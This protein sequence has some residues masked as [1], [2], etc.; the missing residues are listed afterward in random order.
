MNRATRISS[1]AVCASLGCATLTC[2]TPR[3]AAAQAPSATSGWGFAVTPYAW[4][5]G[6]SGTVGVGPLATNVSLDFSQLLRRLRFAA[7]GYGQANYGPAVFA[8]DGIY[9]SLGGEKVVAFR[10]DTGSFTLS[11]HQTLLQPMVGYALGNRLWGV[12]FLAS[13]RYWNMSTDLNAD[14]ANGTSVERS[15]SRD[16]VDAVGGLRA[17]WTPKSYVTVAAGGDAGGG[18]SRDTWQAYGML[19]ANVWHDWT[20]SL[21]YRYLSVNYDRDQFLYDT[22]MTGFVLAATYK[23]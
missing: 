20:V 3:T 16:W 18:G 22:S 14:R 13:A 8:I 4:L 6:L 9:T 21:A 17:Q 11:A 7:M 12:T 5:P 19:G 2:A 1:A 10:G 23:F 15:G